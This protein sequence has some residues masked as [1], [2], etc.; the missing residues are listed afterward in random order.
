MI[1]RGIRMKE[2]TFENIL[3]SIKLPLGELL[4]D[5]NTYR[6]SYYDFPKLHHKY[7]KELSS[8]EKF[9]VLTN[10]KQTVV[11]GVLFY[12]NVDIQITIF[13]E[14]RGMHFMSRIHKNGVLKS[15]CY[16]NQKVTFITNAILSF[17][18]FLMKH[19][20]ISCAGLKIS[21]L[22]E[23]YEY[24]SFFNFHGVKK[25]DEEKFINE[26]S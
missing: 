9:L 6:V 1:N 11:G 4:Y 3:R 12:G 15:E 22:Q 21:N 2:E 10:N 8:L 18:D 19:Y 16:A 24:L 5:G 14:Y 25:Y 26:F 20:L 13:P 23:I 17:D 7:Q